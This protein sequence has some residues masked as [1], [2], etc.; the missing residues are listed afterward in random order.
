L[1]CF[2][3]IDI[4]FKVLLPVGYVDTTEDG[5]CE[6][7]NTCLNVYNIGTSQRLELVFFREAIKH[8]ARLSRVLVCTS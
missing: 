6:A 3:Y 8:A 7:L 1:L 4:A 2:L 5:L